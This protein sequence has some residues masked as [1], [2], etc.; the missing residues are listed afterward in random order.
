[1][2]SLLRISNKGPSPFMP[3]IAGCRRMKVVA[4]LMASIL[5]LLLSLSLSL[6][7][8]S[9][10]RRDGELRIFFVD[11]EGGQA[12]L[13][14]TP[15]KESLLI[16]TGW[17]GNDSRDADRIIAAAQS[18]GARLRRLSRVGKRTSAFCWLISSSGLR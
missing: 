5:L 9:Q 6:Q 15:A 17:P 7:S 14:V 16:D 12:T 11:V 13:F 4:P 3:F 2:I 8:S 10:T 18:A 1:M